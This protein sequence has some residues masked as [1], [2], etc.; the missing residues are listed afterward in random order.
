M[1]PTDEERREVA[2]R[3]RGIEA[4]Q[5]DEGEL[6]DCGEV[7]AELGLASDDGAWY[8]LEDVLRLADL[9]EPEPER[10]CRWVSVEESLPESAG[11]YIV[12][13]HPCYC[14]CVNEAVTLIGMDSFRGKTAWSKRKYQRVTHWM[15]K[16]E[17]P[18]AVVE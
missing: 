18:K 3:L 17:L 7:E 16:P 2:K 6:V 12:A 5:F 14:A 9:I 10:T 15:P 1:M 8:R 11:E 13:Y 4:V